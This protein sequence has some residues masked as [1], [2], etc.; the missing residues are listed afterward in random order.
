[1][2]SRRSFIRTLGALSALGMLA[3]AHAQY[4]TTMTVYMSPAC[5]CCEEWQKHMRASGFRLEINKMADVTPMKQKLAVPESLWSCHTATAGDYVFEGHVPAS[6]V[7]RLL[8]ERA[9]VKGL[10]V[11]GMVA[12]SPGMEQ[13]PPQPY[14]TLAFDE[15]GSQIYER[16]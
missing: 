16:H 2:I 15:R 5:G 14:A 10:A 12:G 11:P 8:R 6:D 13:G 9:K 7:K 4:A 1:M 3:R